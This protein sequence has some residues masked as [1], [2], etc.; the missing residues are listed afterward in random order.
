M[1]L[2][3]SFYNALFVLN[4]LLFSPSLRQS[5]H[6]PSAPLVILGGTL[7]DGTDR[8]P[9]KDSIILLSMGK[10]TA[11][12]KQGQIAIPRNA[13]VINA[14]G[15][16]IVP[17]L[18]DAH[19]HFFQ[20]GGLFTRPDIIDLRN[21]RSYS[22]EIARIQERIPYTLSRYICSGVTSVVDMGGPFWTVALNQRSS[23]L[24]KAPRII[25][26]GPL[27]STY[28]PKELQTSDPP[29]LELGNPEKA[30][31]GVR[32]ILK[33]G[34]ELIKIWFIQTGDPIAQLPG[35]RAA[36]SEAHANGARVVVHATEMAVAR[37]SVEAGADILAHSVSNELVDTSFLQLLKKRNIIYIPT[38][39][40]NERYREILDKKSPKL[41]S[42]EKHC[43][44]P[45]VI[46]TWTEPHSN[47]KRF[48]F[49]SDSI[50]YEN[51]RRVGAA[52]VIIASGSDAGNIGTLHGPSLH[53]ELE[54]MALAG[55]SPKRVLQS[56]TRDAAKVIHPKQDIGT[57]E[58]G[59]L[60]DLLILNADPLS[61]IQNLSKIENVIKGG[62][63]FNP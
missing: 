38:L 33:H 14:Q 29:M 50:A 18:I 42:I 1:G 21:R 9:M 59:M 56:A 54:L 46:V 45:E 49:R 34:A 6:V 55:L 25:A 48:D 40:V 62:Q 2:R 3:N 23:E 27:L 60:A 24:N 11:V 30:R 51:L 37:L 26:A 31:E 43:G 36:I 47:R 4:A 52:G 13:Q 39:M 10:I 41:S 17:G 8:A 20:S 22:D 16:W 63:I 15:K 58:A 5:E 28:I 53:R 7:I 44:D 57:I 19:V 12:G 32:N 61:D 35:L